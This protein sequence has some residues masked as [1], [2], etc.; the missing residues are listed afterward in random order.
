MTKGAAFVRSE[1]ILPEPAVQATKPAERVVIGGPEALSITEGVAIKEALEAVGI[2]ARLFRAD[3]GFRIAEFVRALE[4]AQWLLLACTNNPRIE[5]QMLQEAEK[6]LVP[7]I[8]IICLGATDF[9]SQPRTGLAGVVELLVH[10]RP[11]DVRRLPHGRYNHR[12]LLAVSLVSEA[13]HIARI[14]AGTM[15]F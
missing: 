5:L 2:D 8:G 4:G 3:E 7:K 11:L 1:H 6:A 14:V 12:L 9:L 15:I 10:Q 13:H